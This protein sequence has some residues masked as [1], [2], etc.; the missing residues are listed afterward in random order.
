MTPVRQ[1]IFDF[2]HG[3]CWAACIASIL[4]LPLDC[5]PSFFPEPDEHADWYRKSYLWL[6]GGGLSLLNITL[7]IPVPCELIFPDCYVIVTGPSPRKPEKLHAI[8]GKL[9][10]F[11]THGIGHSFQIELVH[12]PHPSD[13]FFDG[14]DPKEL[15][16]IFRSLEAA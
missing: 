3:N 2:T 12:D 13:L 5:V 1:T 7:P 11:Y 16:F 15:S 6:K 9:E 10:S 8:V 14:S 4:D